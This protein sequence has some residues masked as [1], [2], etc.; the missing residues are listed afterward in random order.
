MEYIVDTQELQKAMIDKGIRTYVEL[1]EKTGVNRNTIA[2]IV[3]GETKP[4]TAVVEKIGAALDLDSEQ[5]G[6]IFFKL[7]LA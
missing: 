3:K 6:R 5:V 7:K 4:S 1:S 2:G